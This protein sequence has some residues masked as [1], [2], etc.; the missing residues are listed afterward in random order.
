LR[1]DNP[2]FSSLELADGPLTGYDIEALTDAP[3]TVVLSSCSTAAVGR[4]VA[5]QTFGVAWAFVAA[6]SRSVVA[7]V[8]PVSDSVVPRLMGELHRRLAH[9]DDASQALHAVQ[10]RA[11]AEPRDVAATAAAF[12]VVGA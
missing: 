3:T 10:Q 12:A 1:R 9:G 4:I 2:L 6:G 5:E 7:P 8:L 11:A